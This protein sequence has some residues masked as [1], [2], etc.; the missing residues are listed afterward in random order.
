MRGPGL[1][2]VNDGIIGTRMALVQIRGIFG[3]VWV[4]LPQLRLVRGSEG[5]AA[6]PHCTFYLRSSV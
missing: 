5:H 4:S 6:L 1:V 2:L 3:T